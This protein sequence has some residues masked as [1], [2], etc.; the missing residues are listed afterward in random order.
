MA[1]IQIE[2]EWLK[3]LIPEGIPTCTSTLITGPGGS[4]K[5]LIGNVIAATWIRHGGSVVFMSLQY[6]N[7]EFIVSG[8]QKV[9]QLELS[10]YKERSVF[11]ELDAASKGSSRVTSRR[12]KANL[13]IPDIWDSAIEQACSMVPDDGPGTMVFGS[14]LNLLLFSPTY[15][16]EILERMKKTIRDD[17]RRTYLF[18]VSTT[19]KADMIAELE[20]NADNLIL[21]RST[22]DPFRLF[23]RIER[24][25]GTKFVADEVE[26]PFIMETL[27][28]V[29]EIAEH[30][31][32]RVIPLVSKI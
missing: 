12:L 3:N 6:P 23:M 30:T 13:V 9:A 11:I 5:P 27:E 28:E 8:I 24:M 29:K 18:S 22:R 32:Q 21:S 4:G 19:A 20:T 17:K 25:K 14:A 7:N 10:E 26:I 16:T 1:N 31:R 2:Q 15:G